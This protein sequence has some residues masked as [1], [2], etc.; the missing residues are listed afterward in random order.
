MPYCQFCGNEVSDQARF[1]RQCGR[2]TTAD[3]T[4]DQPVVP[5]QSASPA[6]ELG[7][8]DAGKP[9]GE[10]EPQDRKSLFSTPVREMS[11]GQKATLGCLGLIAIFI[12]IIVVCSLLLTAGDNYDSG[13]SPGEPSLTEYW[14]RAACADLYQRIDEAYR[15][16]YTNEE[17]MASF[18]RAEGAMKR[19]GPER[20]IL[21]CDQK[22]GR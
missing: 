6:R 22:F 2:P 5:P 8:A 7:P 18:H 21:H 16:G 14:D 3:A 9:G 11:G 13:Y 10:T 4:D 17:L 20:V 1:C 12:P 15:R 19:Y